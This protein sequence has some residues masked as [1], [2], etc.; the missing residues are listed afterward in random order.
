MMCANLKAAAKECL[1][2][3]YSVFMAKTYFFSHCAASLAQ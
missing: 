2:K 1:I 3:R